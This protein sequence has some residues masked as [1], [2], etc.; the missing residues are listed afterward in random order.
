[1]LA[2]A[3]LLTSTSADTAGTGTAGGDV[4]ATAPPLSGRLAE[5]AAQELTTAAIDPPPPPKL[6][7]DPSPGEAAVVPILS[8]SLHES[9]ED[10]ERLDAIVTRK[11]F[12][13][14]CCLFARAYTRL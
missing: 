10:T 14:R 12:D 7:G 13:V 8:F 4:A 5:A 1:M 2:A 9:L 6:A 11:D 3:G